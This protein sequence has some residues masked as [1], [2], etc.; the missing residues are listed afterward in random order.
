[1]GPLIAPARSAVGRLE[2]AGVA[3]AAPTGLHRIAEASRLLAAQQRREALEVLDEASALLPDR[4]LPLRLK[5]EAL[6]DLGRP[7][8]ALAALD[9]AALREPGHAPLFTVRARVLGALGRWEECVG[10]LAEASALAPEAAAPWHQRAQAEE[11]LGRKADA[12]RSWGEFLRRV[13]PD[14]KA[15]EAARSRLAALEREAV[16]ALRGGNGGSAARSSADEHVR[17]AES[18][19]SAGRVT[20][21]AQAFEEALAHDEGH[22][23]ALHGRGL[24]AAQAGRVEEAL[25]FFDRALAREPRFAVARFH[26]GCAEDELG[27]HA[28]ASRSFQAFL[29]DSPADLAPQ[30][31]HARQRLATLRG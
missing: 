15:A 24:V 4:A 30:I 20:E 19:R 18:L 12:A 17:R 13:R 21:A 10:M 31:E 1:M 9:E 16:N 23:A 29:A 11:R 28:E 7:R 8:D 5:A 25:A 27:R 2:A 3:P 22:V 26:K 14:T 6:V